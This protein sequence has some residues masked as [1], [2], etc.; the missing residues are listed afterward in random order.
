MTWGR[1]RQLLYRFRSGVDLDQLNGWIQG[2]YD[3]I[4]DFHPWKGLE[5]ETYLETLAVYQTGTV[6]VTKGATA[7]TTTG[8]WT[9]FTGRKIRVGGRS[10]LYTITYSGSTWALDR[11]YEGET[12]A[13]ASYYVFQNVY[14]L[15]GDLKT[16]TALDSPITG[17]P[18]ACWTKEQ[19]REAVGRGA[20][21]GPPAAYAL[22]DA[23]DVEI[24]RVPVN[25][26]GIPLRYIKTVAGFTGANTGEAPLTWVPANAI[27]EGVRADILADLGDFSGSDR[28]DKSFGLQLSNM[29]GNEAIRKGA[30]PLRMASE[31]TRHRIERG[32][33]RRGNFRLP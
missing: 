21:L 27:L 22:T 11:T 9:G 3:F 28:R 25:A 17:V 16:L 8:T 10:E 29:A 31:Y 1:I 19:L 12:D 14:A 33:A 2:R 5:V 24:W 6:S 23:G 20:Q 32:L 13:A 7:I 15:P 18:L 30:R 4:L 26:V